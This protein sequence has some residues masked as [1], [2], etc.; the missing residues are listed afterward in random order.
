VLS[1]VLAVSF[2][3]GL[4]RFDRRLKRPDEAEEAYGLPLLAVLPHSAA[5]APQEQGAA[6]LGADLRESFRA[7]RTSVELSH[8]DQPARTIVVTS[9]VRGEGKSTVVRNLALAFA[10]A[11]KRVAVVECDLR[12]PSLAEMFGQDHGAGLTEVLSGEKR[13]DDTILRARA[14]LPA[15]NSVFGAAGSVAA[16][17]GGSGAQADESIG[18]VT[19]LLS[20]ATPANPPRVLSSTRAL[21]VLDEI[22]ASHDVTIIDSAPLL[23]VTDSVPL[24]R[25]A[26]SIILVGRLSYTT[27]DTAKRLTAFLKR[28]PDTHIVGVVAND[29]MR[30]ESLGYGY[31]AEY[32]Y[33]ETPRKA[34]KKTRTPKASDPA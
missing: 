25:Y 3:F 4:E 1:L 18:I 2:A 6:A 24:L 14:R 8:L 17:N 16:S 5:P 20:G 9:G 26:D 34:A 30:L 28:V 12:R 29:L 21:E 19:L 27:R 15:T 33:E 7:L 32:G 22:A 23:S 10:E 31:G 13:L 11:G